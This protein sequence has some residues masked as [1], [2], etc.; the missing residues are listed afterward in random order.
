MFNF[1][2]S[3]GLCSNQPK[4]GEYSYEVYNKIPIIGGPM[5][6]LNEILSSP[7]ATSQLLE[8]HHNEPNSF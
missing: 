6:N 3:C 8:Q 2:A 1:L 4:S 5:G 7:Q